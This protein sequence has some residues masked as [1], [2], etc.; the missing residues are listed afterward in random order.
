MGAGQ[1]DRSISVIVPAYNSEQFLHTAL[2]SVVGQIVSPTE[3]IVVNDCSTDGT[4]EVARA[5]D[6]RLP[7]TIIDKPVNGGLG[8]AR[9]SAGEVASGELLALLDADDAWF[10]DHLQVM[11]ALF[12]DDRSLVTPSTLRWYPGEQLGPT[13]STELFPIPAPDEQLLQLLDF[14][15]LFSGCVFARSTY[16]EVGGFSE[17][18]K[19]E[20]WELWIRML[21]AGCTVIGAPTP[22][23]LYRQHSESLSSADGTLEH[24]IEMYEELLEQGRSS[25]ERE[26]IERALRRRHARRLMLDG[27]DAYV[28]GDVRGGRTRLARALVQ[29]RSFRGGRSSRSG[30]VTL[31]SAAAL[32]RPKWATAKRAERNT[33]PSA[34]RT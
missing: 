9:R 24:D 26:V 19:N 31:R 22:T 33:D 27:L 10:P 6:N 18:R 16:L 13:G 3:V 5:W 32:A 15:Y 25:A 2:A 29:D 23:V 8:A 17:R 1:P 14:N 11:L 30:S 20:D 12:E 34:I 28:V 4:L 21:S 7:L